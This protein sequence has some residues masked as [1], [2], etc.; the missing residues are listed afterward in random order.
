MCWW[1]VGGI[2]NNSAFL[3]ES[4]RRRVARWQEMTLEKASYVLSCR[5]KKEVEKVLSK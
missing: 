1:E 2:L 4:A 3:R 5:Q